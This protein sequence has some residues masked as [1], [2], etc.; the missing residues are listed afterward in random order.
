MMVEADGERVQ[1]WRMEGKSIDRTVGGRKNMAAVKEQVIALVKAMPDDST[2]ED[3]M[4]KLYFKLQ[5]DA[6]L[7]ELDRGDG[8]PHE[9]V[10]K[11]MAEWLHD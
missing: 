2:I 10:E 4:E 11:R 7:A 8:I 5:V 9:E 6:G 3:V 1:T